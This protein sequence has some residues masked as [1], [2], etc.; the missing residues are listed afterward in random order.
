MSLRVNGGA[1]TFIL[2]RLEKKKQEA[3]YVDFT[4]HCMLHLVKSTS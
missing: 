1:V 4:K 2:L 3:S